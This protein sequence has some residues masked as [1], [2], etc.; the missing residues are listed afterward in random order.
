MLILMMHRHSTSLLHILIHSY[1]PVYF[2]LC[3][4]AS[5]IHCYRQS[6]LTAIMPGVHFFVFCNFL[7]D[8]RHF[9]F[10]LLEFGQTLDTSVFKPL[11]FGQTLDTSVF[12]PLEFDGINDFHFMHH[13][14]HIVF[15][16]YPY[17]LPPGLLLI[18][19]SITGNR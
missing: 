13:L 3:S 10:K 16:I 17:P 2:Y 14:L 18:I 12:E 15:L 6:I 5:L 1:L 9:I 19:S 11:E 7:P 4:F 8:S